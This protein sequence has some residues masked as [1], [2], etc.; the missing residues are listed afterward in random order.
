MNDEITQYVSSHT[1]FLCRMHFPMPRHMD[2]STR[3]SE[4]DRHNGWQLASWHGI[5]FTLWF[6]KTDTQTHHI[7]LRLKCEHSG[8]KN[9]TERWIRNETD[10]WQWQKP[11]PTYWTFQWH[12]GYPCGTQSKDSHIGVTQQQGKSLSGKYIF[13]RCIHFLLLGHMCLY[14]F[15]LCTVLGLSNRAGL[16]VSWGRAVCTVNWEISPSSGQCW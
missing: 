15:R 11:L 13:F 14:P 4:A 6:I 8:E 2:I 5:A 16:W 9:K 3:W 10:T 12:D 1:Q 7:H